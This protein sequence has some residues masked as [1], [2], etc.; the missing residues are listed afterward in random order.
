[1]LA[2]VRLIGSLPKVL[3]SVDACWLTEH[4]CEEIA[5]VN[6]SLRSLSSS[7][8]W[9]ESELWQWRSS[10]PFRVPV[11]TVYLVTC[12]ARL[13]LIHPKV[14]T[15]VLL[16][17]PAV[18][19]ATAVL[20]LAPVTI[21][22]RFLLRRPKLALLFTFVFVQVRL[23]PIILPIMRI[24]TLVSLMTLRFVI[25]WTPDCLE[26]EH[27]EVGIRFH[28]VKHVNGQFFLGVSKGAQVSKFALIH[29]PRPLVAKLALILFRV[30]KVFDTIVGSV[31]AISRRARSIV[32]HM[33]THF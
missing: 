2:R 23:P 13:A 10:L 31:T 5:R 26:V 16:F 27:V 8:P 3:H 4:R 30:V 11:G 18:T 12:G 25:E 17:L 1:M 22:L 14:V 6:Y 7:I 33:G 32:F 24:L 21:R 28:L 19:V 9:K 20:Q 15:V 29:L